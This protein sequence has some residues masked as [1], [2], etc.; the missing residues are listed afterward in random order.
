MNLTKLDNPIIRFGLKHKYV[1]AYHWSCE[2]PPTMLLNAIFKF[3]KLTLAI[4][5]PDSVPNQPPTIGSGGACL[6]EALVLFCVLEITQEDM[7]VI[8]YV[9]PKPLDHLSG[10]LSDLWRQAQ[11]KIIRGHHH[12]AYRICLLILWVYNRSLSLIPPTRITSVHN[13]VIYIYIVP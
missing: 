5:G 12:V 8:F 1:V 6:P 10:I 3:P 13:F 9:F 4:L 11:I 7:R 2:G